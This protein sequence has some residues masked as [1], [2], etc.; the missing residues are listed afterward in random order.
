MYYEIY[1][2]NGTAKDSGSNSV[3]GHENG[4]LSR[5]G[6]YDRLGLSHCSVYYSHPWIVPQWPLTPPLPQRTST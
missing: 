2:M 6:G 3:Y 4:R 1:L 5:K